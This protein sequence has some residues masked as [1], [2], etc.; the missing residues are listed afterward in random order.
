MAFNVSEGASYAVLYSVLA[1]F[2][3]CAIASGDYF[4]SCLPA[5]LNNQ[6]VLRKNTSETT[7]GNVNKNVDFFLSA[8]NS[9]T[10]AQIAFSIF[11]SSMGAWVLY[12]PTELGATPSL[13]WIA[14]IGYA[15]ASASPAAISFFLGPIIKARCTD[16]SFNFTDFGL[17]RYG[18]LMQ[19]VIG[20]MGIFYMFIF[21]VAEL[22]TISGAYATIHNDFSDNSYLITIIISLGAVTIL[23]TSLGGLPA[24]IITDK[25]QAVLMLILVLTLIFAVSLNPDNRLSEDQFARAS[26][27]TGE[28]FMAAVTLVFAI[29]SAEM[30]NLSTWQRVWAAKNERD[31][32]RGFAGASILIFLLMMFF[33]ILGMIA[34]ALDPDAYDAGDKLNFLAFFDIL[35]PL[36]PFWHIVT[37]ILVTAL[38]ASSI[39]SLQNGIMSALSTDL[40]QMGWN[41]KWVARL[42]LVILNVPAVVLSARGYDVLALFL[43][44]DLICA[45][46]VLPVF[47]GLMTE[48]KGMIPAPT[49]FGALLGIAAGVITVLVIGLIVDAPGGLF[50]YFL[51]PN[52]AVCALCGFKTMITFIVTPLSAGLFCLL[53]SK[54]DIMCRGENARAPLLSSCFGTSGGKDY[55]EGLE[56][57][58]MEE[59]MPEQYREQHPDDIP[60][61]DIPV[62]PYKGYDS[63]DQSVS[64]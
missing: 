49:E 24:S 38:A 31:M 60:V 18:R 34:Y 13:S 11:A 28:G 19:V 14:V 27:W 17:Q 43:V 23:Y 36:A 57:P 2:T 16:S 4:H 61:D 21:L 42:L 46:A 58:A 37:L 1:F 56:K 39:D 10:A 62:V 26:N 52:D 51:L 25:F 8:R 64:A 45:T 53:F 3:L 59:A 50:E 6:F 48:D 54:L 40:V 9:A 30:F 47:L 22:T 7:N 5:W 33:G 20:L 44:A 29:L 63:D 35:A 41:P 12:A 32:K 15:L 55:E